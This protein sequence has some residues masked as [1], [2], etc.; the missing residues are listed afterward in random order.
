M[1]STF[2]DPCPI[3]SRGLDPEAVENFRDAIF[4]ANPSVPFRKM[5]LNSS[6]IVLV[7][8]LV[9]KVARGSVL[10]KILAQSMLLPQLI[11]THPVQLPQVREYR[12]SNHRQ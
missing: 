3:K 2:Y 8:S 4:E 1:S 10:Q 12:V 7:D 5:A 9:G 6:D 11:L